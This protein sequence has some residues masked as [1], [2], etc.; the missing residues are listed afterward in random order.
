MVVSALISLPLSVHI[1]LFQMAA[2][3]SPF[4]GDKMDLYSLCKK[5]EQCDYPPLPSDHYSEEVS[6]VRLA[7]APPPH[8]GYGALD[9]LCFKSTP[10]SLGSQPFQSFL[11][12][13]Q[14]FEASSSSEPVLF[15]LSQFADFEFCWQSKWVFFFFFF[16]F[17]IKWNLPNCL[18]HDTAPVLLSD[19]KIGYD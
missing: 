1:L 6:A 4:Y 14:M 16:F 11:K 9:P 8:R 19:Q 18:S 2:L 5:I 17:F 7:L 3:Q 15:S 10:S 13:L 12:I